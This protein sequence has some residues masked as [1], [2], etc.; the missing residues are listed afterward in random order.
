[1]VTSGH[2]SSPHIP[3]HEPNIA[4]S[5][6][7]RA[8]LVGGCGL[9]LIDISLDDFLSLRQTPDPEAGSKTNSARPEI[10]EKCQLFITDGEYVYMNSVLSRTVSNTLV[11][12]AKN[13]PGSDTN[14]FWGRPKTS[15]SL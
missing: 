11:Q 10:A 8:I 14:E 12:D 15:T 4:V 9:G 1:M 13:T 6:R 3:S 7:D 5:N 2:T